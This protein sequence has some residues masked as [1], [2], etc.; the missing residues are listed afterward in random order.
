MQ[1]DLVEYS[2]YLRNYE[3][4]ATDVLLKDLSKTGITEQCIFNSLNNF[5]VCDNIVFDIMH[6]LFEGVAKYDICKILSYLIIEKKYFT[7]DMLNYRKQMFNYGPTEIGNLSKEITLAHLKS[8]TIK[9]TAREMMTFIHFLPLILTDLIPRNDQ[10]G[11]FLITL[12]KLVDMVLKTSFKE[13]DIEN[14]DKIIF[15][16]N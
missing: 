14:L 11:K 3:N 16:H 15:E 12:V 5:H 13:T 7:L 4:Y 2:S 1:S 8:N 10:V 6:D 9:M